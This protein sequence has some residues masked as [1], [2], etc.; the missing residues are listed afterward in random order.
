MNLNR[1]QGATEKCAS[2][3]EEV[4]AEYKTYKKLKKKDDLDSNKESGTPAYLLSLKWLRM[5]QKFIF[6]DQL[7]NHYNI[8]K[9][10]VEDED[11]FTKNHPGPI[12]NM[13]DLCEDDDDH[14]NL[15][16]SGT[17]K[18]QTKEC[19]DMYLDHNKR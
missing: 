11:H 3:L 8:E 17:L 12:N 15:Y 10:V 5:Y 2:N 7:D 19:I 16:G 14:V 18:N 6:Q 4:F 13:E 9:V 1:S